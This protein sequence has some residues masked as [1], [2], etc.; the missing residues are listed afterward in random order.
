MI[1]SC[2]EALADIVVSEHSTLE[3]RFGGAP[4]NIAVGLARLGV[5]SA[6]YGGLSTDPIGIG[7]AEILRR[8]G[9]DCR[10]VNVCNAPSMLAVVGISKSGSPS[11][12]FPVRSGAD[13]QFSNPDVVAGQKFEAVVFGSYLA[14]DAYTGPILVDL[15]QRLRSDAIVFFDPNVRPAIVPDPAIWRDGIDAFLSVADVIKVSEEDIRYAYGA[16]ADRSQLASTWLEREPTAIIVTRGAQGAEVY[17]RDYMVEV[18]ATT[19]DVVDTV[20]AGDAFLVGLLASLR[21]S[22]GL[23]RITLRTPAHPSVANALDFAVLLAGMTCSRRGADI[24][25]MDDLALGAMPR[26]H[27]PS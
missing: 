19:V 16:D 10:F 25:R 20:G 23:N 21:R 5:P 3:A 24:P 8:E 2:G 26:S 18:G 14:A 15:A 12:V 17:T 22:G 4:F 6:F 11:Y 9:V 7:L 27:E 13:K 1:L